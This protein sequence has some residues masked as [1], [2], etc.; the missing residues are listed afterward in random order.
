MLVSYTEGTGTTECE[1]QA[2]VS[3]RNRLQPCYYG[4]MPLL[5]LKDQHPLSLKKRPRIIEENPLSVSEK[6][7]SE[8][9]SDDES[10]STCLESNS[11][12][13]ENGNGLLDKKD[14]VDASQDLTLAQMIVG[15]GIKKYQR[16]KLSTIIRGPP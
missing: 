2:L 12:Q 14:V 8:D 9:D 16:H 6:S 10:R 15:T 11:E 3:V 5:H 13:L 1:E 7:D 4:F